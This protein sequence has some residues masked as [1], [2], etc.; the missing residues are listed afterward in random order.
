MFIDPTLA[1]PGYAR[2]APAAGTTMPRRFV[3]FGRSP[4]LDAPDEQ[5][6]YGD[7]PDWAQ[8]NPARI[9]AALAHALSRPGGGWAVL[10]ASRR[11]RP[12]PRLFRVNG[13]DLA[14]WRRPDG[15][16]GAVPDACPHMGASLCKG[17]VDAAGRL[18]C[19]WHGLSLGDRRR[20]R[21]TPFPAHDDGVLTWVRLPALLAPGEAPTDRPVLAPRPATFLDGVIRTEARCE[22]RDVIANR[23]DPW[24]GVHFHPHSFLRLAVI[25]EDDAQITVRVV[26]RVAPFVGMEVDA[27]F[28]CPDPRTIVMTIVAGEGV[29][30]VVET[31]ATPI[32]DGRTA[33][34]EATLATSSRAAFAWVRPIRA[35]VRPFI[36]ARAARLWVDDV[37]YAERMYALRRQAP[38]VRG[39]P[40]LRVVPGSS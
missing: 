26:Y 27:R 24:H 3:T 9:E 38:V 36:E 13:L 39:Q 25:A 5:P 2:A 19:P 18:V 7:R 32:D 14:V 1:E 34:I 37:E 4:A 6:L 29:G 8:A 12:A 17:S 40:R 35:L 10:D 33:M 20:G 11:I 31:H 16:V 22:P 23:L 21:W 30:S 28:H 15:T